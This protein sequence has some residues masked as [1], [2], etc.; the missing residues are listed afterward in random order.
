MLSIH[1]LQLMHS[2]CYELL[3][4]N[5]FDAVSKGMSALLEIGGCLPDQHMLP[6]IAAF[7]LYVEHM[8]CRAAREGSRPPFQLTSTVI[9][10]RIR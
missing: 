4:T 5:A 6:G 2:G 9:V 3:C 1:D 8:L 7:E 10:E